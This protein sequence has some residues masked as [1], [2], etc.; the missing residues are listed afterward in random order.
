VWYAHT[1]LGHN[2]GELFHAIRDWAEKHYAEILTARENYDERAAQ[3]PQ[4]IS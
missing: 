2:A 1:E 3:E 4:P